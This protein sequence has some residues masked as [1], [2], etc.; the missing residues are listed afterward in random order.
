MI[1][2]DIE[3]YVVEIARTDSQNPVRSLLVRID[4]DDGREGWGETPWPL[5]PDERLP[6]RHSLLASLQGRSIFDV[7]E[8][9][10][11]DEL[12]A[13]SLRAVVEM[14][15][16]DL[17]GRTLKQPLCRLWGGEYRPMAPIA[18][19]LPPA[20]G[21]RVA[22]VAWALAEQGHLTQ[23]VAASGNADDDLRTLADVRAR[24]GASVRLRF[25][26]GARYDLPTARDLCAEM[27]R[28]PPQFFL[29]PLN[30]RDFFPLA[31]LGRQTSVPLAVGR[32]VTTPADAFMAVRA[33]AAPFV[34]IELS[35][36]G[37]LTAARKAAEVVAAGGATPVLGGGASVGIATAAML[38]LVAATPAFSDASECDYHQIQDD[39]LSRPLSV[40]EGMM[41]VPRNPGLGV[42]VDREKV[43]T[44][45]VG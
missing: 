31:G 39:V 3:F 2:N 29:D 38:Q 35:R 1:I 25:D 12:D 32:A 43:E 10:E 28:D 34:A 24:V 22:E 19:C 14:A 36:V 4:S 45:Q 30:T 16:W 11:L 15:S 44:Y 33:G 5:W 40:A 27:E 23:S 18:V 13:A 9:L 26:G 20:A 37:G 42:E 21:T 8:L 41:P 6:R 7:E 17:I